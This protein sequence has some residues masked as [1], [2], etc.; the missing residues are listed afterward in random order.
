MYPNPKSISDHDAIV[1]T[2]LGKTFIRMETRDPQAIAS[3]IPSKNLLLQTTNV[4]TELG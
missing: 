3:A 4:M 1:E 2:C